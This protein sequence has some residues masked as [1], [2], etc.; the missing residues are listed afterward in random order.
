MPQYISSVWPLL[1]CLPWPSPSYRWNSSKVLGF[2]TQVYESR[3]GW[4]Y[5]ANSTQLLLQ[6]PVP[7]PPARWHPMSQYIQV[8]SILKCTLNHILTCCLKALAE[9]HYRWG[10][11]RNCQMGV[12]AANQSKKQALGGR[13]VWTWKGSFFPIGSGSDP[14]PDPPDMFLLWNV[15]MHKRHNRYWPPG[16]LGRK[17]R[18]VL[19]TSIEKK[20]NMKTWLT[21]QF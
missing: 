16:A 18:H 3:R 8:Y 19:P 4:L 10:N 9:G 1:K 13:W 20:T 17:A 7:S 2:P 21:M 11:H 6:I 14:T 5:L 12:T 15:Q